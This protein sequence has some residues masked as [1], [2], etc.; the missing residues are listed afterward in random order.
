M[1]TKDNLIDISEPPSKKSTRNVEWDSKTEKHPERREMKRVI[2][3]KESEDEP[4]KETSAPP[5]PPEPSSVEEELL[6]TTENGS[7]NGIMENV[8]S[9]SKKKRVKRS[10]MTNPDPPPL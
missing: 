10:L 9:I 8:S 5:P 3:S 2:P 4:L 1:K 6:P 7:N